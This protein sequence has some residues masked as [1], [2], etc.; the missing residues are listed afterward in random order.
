MVGG[1]IEDCLTGRDYGVGI[2][3]IK[4]MRSI[5]AYTNDSTEENLVKLAK[6]AASSLDGGTERE[7]SFIA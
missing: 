4:D 1:K 6:V 2:R 3:I 7:L 5:Y